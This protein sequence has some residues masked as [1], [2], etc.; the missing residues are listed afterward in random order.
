M[1]I[2]GR[3]GLPFR[4]FSF[5]DGEETAAFPKEGNKPTRWNIILLSRENDHE[6]GLSVNGSRSISIPIT[7]NQPDIN[8]LKIGFN[9]SAEVLNGQI[10]EIL[11]YERN[12]TKD[13]RKGLTSI[14]PVNII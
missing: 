9:D 3:S 5:Y 6:I 11:M 7:D 13:E 12:L 8:T 10:A 1:D 14:Y 4:L 2:P